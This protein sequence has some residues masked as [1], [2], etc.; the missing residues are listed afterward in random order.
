MKTCPQITQIPLRVDVTSK[1][2]YSVFNSGYGEEAAE[3]ES[4]QNLNKIKQEGEGMTI[5]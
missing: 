3:Y 5:G 2:N 4:A 1:E